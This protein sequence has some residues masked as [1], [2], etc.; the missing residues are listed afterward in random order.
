DVY[1]RQNIQK[2]VGKILSLDTNKTVT[3]NKNINKTL[4]SST[5]KNLSM[6][7]G[8]SFSITLPYTTTKSVVATQVF[9]AAGGVIPIE[10]LPSFYVGI[11]T[12]GN[13][14]NMPVQFGAGN[15]TIY[16]R[17]DGVYYNAS[18]TNL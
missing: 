11:D 2:T 4:S 18:F 16:Y 15:R 13:L 1:K 7:Q 8:L 10:S 12:L 9:Q 14:I 6:Q 3:I 17:Y 5:S